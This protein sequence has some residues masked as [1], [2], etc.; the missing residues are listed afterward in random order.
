MSRSKARRRGWKRAGV[1]AI[2][3]SALA[4]GA[5]AD[6]GGASQEELAKKLANPI[7]S[8]IS[9]PFQYNWDTGIGPDDDDRHLVNVQP[10]I[11]LPI[12]DTG[13]NL[14][15]RTILPIIYLDEIVPGTGD[16]FGLGDIVQS[17]FLSPQKPVAGF[18]WGAG[19]VFLFPSATDE[20]LGGDEWGAGPT[21]VVLRQD[22]G[23]TW[24]VLANHIWSYAGSGTHVSST[25]LQPF[26]SYSTKTATTFFLQT[27]STY[28]WKAD[29][30][31]VPINFG[32]NQLLKLGGLRF[33]VGVGGRY[34]AETPPGGPD[35]GVR[36]N[37]V[38]LFPR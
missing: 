31:S 27:E 25:F 14:I 13:W 6:G 1:A 30:W 11:P 4:S 21:G 38:L 19:P 32:V 24:G 33:Q 28:D 37:L 22:G 2:A 17:L 29:Q 9:V 20:L 34:W 18:I 36:G 8:L 5:A 15:S 16:T 3:A 12:F 23:L 26:L 7:S 10:V 35:W